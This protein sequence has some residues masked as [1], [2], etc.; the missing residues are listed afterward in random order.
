MN[1]LVEC[2]M[3]DMGLAARQIQGAWRSHYFRTTSSRTLVG[4]LLVREEVRYACCPRAYCLLAAMSVLLPA[5][6]CE[7]AAVS[8]LL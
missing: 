5:C 2:M 7:R 8:V 4:R 6:C 3:Y 1:K